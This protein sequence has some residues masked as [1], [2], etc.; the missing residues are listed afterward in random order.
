SRKVFL[1][2]RSWS[3]ASCPDCSIHVVPYSPIRGWVA[4][5]QDRTT[6]H[7]SQALRFWEGT[8]LVCRAAVWLQSQ[9]R[10]RACLPFPLY[11][12]IRSVH[13]RRAWNLREIGCRL[14]RGKWEYRCP[15]ADFA[16][17]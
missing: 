4:Q 14:Q 5:S 13:P 9:P 1:S 12:I 17:H 7:I 16:L 8:A 2:A 11:F 15:V 10:F 6:S 3:F